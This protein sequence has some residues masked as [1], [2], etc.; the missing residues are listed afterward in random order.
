LQPKR[1]SVP[2]QIKVANIT[3]MNREFVKAMVPEGW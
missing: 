3:T 1:P 2:E